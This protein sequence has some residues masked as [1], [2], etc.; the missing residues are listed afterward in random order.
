MPNLSFLHFDT[1]LRTDQ[2]DDPF[3][4]T[5]TLANP[6]RNIKKIYLKSCEIPLGF[7][8]FRSANEFFFTVRRRDYET[9]IAFNGETFQPLDNHII[10]KSIPN[11]QN[12][13]FASD[14][15]PTRTIEPANPLENQ[16]EVSVLPL[17]YKI[18]IPA[19]NFSIDSLIEFINNEVK[20]LNKKLMIE[21]KVNK[22]LG[23]LPIYLTKLT[24]NESGIFPVGFVRLVCNISNT[25]LQIYSNNQLTTTLLGFDPY[26]QNP[27]T[28]KHITAPRLWGI[29]NDLALYLYFP[30]IPHNNTHFGMQ[31]LSFK[32]PMSAGYQAIAFNA[33]S[34]NFSQYVEISDTHFILNNLKIA[35][36][37]T[38]GNLLVNQYNWQ[39]TLGFET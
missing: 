6:L 31:L 16:D 25:A 26:Q 15:D 14:H 9:D 27:E 33:E 30:N 10:L 13:Y 36:Y 4:C 23:E 20:Q 32:I 8:N 18:T 1:A 29:Y 17:T 39:F 7:F 35:V 3:N 12:I 34:Q 2:N 38:R 5:L 21:Y 37:D 11:T 22:N 28:L 24:L 19:G